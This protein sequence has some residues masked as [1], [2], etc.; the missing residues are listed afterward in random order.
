M[1]SHTASYV[2]HYLCYSLSLLPEWALFQMTVEMCYL[3]VCTALPQNLQLAWRCA[4]PWTPCIILR[5]RHA[6]ASYAAC[7]GRHFSLVVCSC[8][9]KAFTRSMAS[10]HEA[11]HTAQHQAASNDHLNCTVC[12]KISKANRHDEASYTE[13][14]AKPDVEAPPEETQQADAIT[15]N[16][17]SSHHC[18]SFPDFFKCNLPRAYSGSKRNTINTGASYVG[19]F[20]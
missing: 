11:S 19:S 17:C 20:V 13:H 2:K 8:V 6:A 9:S 12:A 5:Y 4:C 1:T 7:P 18:D 14:C 16:R 15:V 3:C 10:V